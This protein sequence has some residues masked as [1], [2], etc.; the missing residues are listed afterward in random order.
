MQDCRRNTGNEEF[1]M[2]KNSR[3]LGMRLDHK[4]WQNRR[5]THWAKIGNIVAGYFKAKAG[6]GDRGMLSRSTIISGRH[7][8]VHS[9]DGF[10]H[11]RVRAAYREACSAGQLEITR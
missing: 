5:A 4:G 3:M 10:D 11:L 1:G 6:L 8:W 9:R 7:D 2:K